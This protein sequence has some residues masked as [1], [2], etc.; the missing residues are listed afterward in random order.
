MARRPCGGDLREA[1]VHKSTRRTVQ[2]L[3]LPDIVEE[4]NRTSHVKPENAVDQVAQKLHLEPLADRL[5][6]NY[7]KLL[8]RYGVSSSRRQSSRTAQFLRLAAGVPA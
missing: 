2:R 6:D 1:G 8:T 3:L 7:R 4:L 5:C